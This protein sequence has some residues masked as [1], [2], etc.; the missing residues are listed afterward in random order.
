M[1]LT[2]HN[3]SGFSCLG[4]STFLHVR[5]RIFSREVVIFFAFGV[6][7]L[8]EESLSLRTVHFTPG[9]PTCPRPNFPPKSPPS[10]RVTNHNTSCQ[11]AGIAPPDKMEAFCSFALLDDKGRWNHTLRIAIQTPLLV[12][13]H[14]PSSISHFINTHLCISHLTT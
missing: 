7:S 1:G 10:F 2:P 4:A 3:S 13:R 6:T 14:R 11:Q 12:S 9:Y 5:L 8:D